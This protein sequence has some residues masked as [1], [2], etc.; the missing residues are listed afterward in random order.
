MT[1]LRRRRV[2]QSALAA[3]V[4]GASGL[5]GAAAVA[6]ATRGGYFRAALGGARG[7]DS[8]DARTHAGLFMSAAAQGAVFDTLTEVA[9]G[10]ALRGELATGWSASPDA[11][12]WT[13]D[14]RPGVRFHNGKAFGAEDVLAS[15]ALHRDAASPARPI[16]AEIEE[17]RATAPHQV[18]FTL[19]TGNADFPYLLADYHLLIYPAGQ[20]AEAMARGIGT[21]LYRVERFEPGRRFI[22]HRVAE[23][24]KDGRAGWFDGVDFLAMNDPRDRLEAMRSGRVDAI[25]RLPAAE[26]AALQAEPRFT[27]QSLAGNQHYGFA[28]RTDLAPFADPHLRQALKAAV[29]REAMVAEVLHGHGSIGQ[30]SPIGP[31]NPYFAALEPQG[32]DPD[33]AR[34]HLAQAGHERIALPMLVSE[35]AFDGAGRAAE[36]YRESAA[37][38]GI[39][40]E[41][42]RLPPE[43]HWPRDSAGFRAGG[44]SGRATE[45]WAFSTVL[46]EAAPWNA[47]R[48]GS[49]RFGTLLREA[50]AE[51]DS[52]RRAELYAEMQRIS[53]DEG[54]L[55]LP[56][57]ANHLQ[58]HSARIATP[59]R[60]GAMRAMDDSR[61]AERWWMA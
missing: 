22:G 12:V 43:T 19:A 14:L 46:T 37:Q 3:A 27:V 55:I 42:R 29:D 1:A 25:D 52:T 11:R 44:W 5:A 41:L 6:G 60:V 51:F 50:R 47:T 8:W 53:R 23:H 54:G 32:F 59:K 39:A 40:L 36:L 61:M 57:Y 17:M 58:A 2:L 38:A 15:L 31:A 30:D 4:L 24:Y 9:A 45:D 56:M 7:T 34:W 16:V 26:A 10:G 33:R 18:Q 49:G 35:A 20:I 21:G 13:F 48:G 28:L